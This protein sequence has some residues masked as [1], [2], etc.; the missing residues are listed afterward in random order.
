M[1]Q[2]RIP[3]YRARRDKEFRV[4]SATGADSKT[5]VERSVIQGLRL[6][7]ARWVNEGGAGDDEPPPM[8]PALKRAKSNRKS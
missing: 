7:I 6:Q 4:L 8:P 2:S 1:K 3:E 5:V